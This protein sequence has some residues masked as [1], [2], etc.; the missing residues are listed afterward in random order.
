MLV[1]KRKEENSGLLA[2]ALTQ[3]LVSF[4]A[5]EIVRRVGDPQPVTNA[6]RLRG[7]KYF[8]QIGFIVVFP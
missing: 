3:D 7:I 4:A 6:A 8:V 1:R 2:T 5:P